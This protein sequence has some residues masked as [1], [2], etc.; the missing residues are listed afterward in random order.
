MT[1]IAPNGVVVFSG[2]VEVTGGTAALLQAL[3]QVIEPGA[4]LR[5]PEGSSLPAGA[6]REHGE[7]GH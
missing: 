7:H 3:Q 6:P 5:R 1:V 4:A 2:R